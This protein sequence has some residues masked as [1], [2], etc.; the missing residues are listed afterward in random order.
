MQLFNRLFGKKDSVN[1]DWTREEK[2]HLLEQRKMITYLPRG[3]FTDIS[4]LAGCTGEYVRKTLMVT[5]PFSKNSDKVK[6]IWSLLPDA[7]ERAKKSADYPW[8][9]VKRVVDA[10]KRNESVQVRASYRVLKFLESKLR[11]NGVLFSVEDKGDS[12]YVLK[13]TK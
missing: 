8:E 13:P 3:I 6:V 5:K 10:V 2:A 4:K 11:K 9:E 7:I 12:T 1:E